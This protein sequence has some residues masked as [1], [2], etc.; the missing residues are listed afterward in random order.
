MICKRFLWIVTLLGL[1]A[2]VEVKA[3][4]F[5][6]YGGAN[7]QI[8][9][10]AEVSSG[11]TFNNY[12]T[13]QLGSFSNGFDLP[14]GW[15]Y[16]VR[17]NGNFT[18]G[19]SSIPA[20]YVSLQLG[21][22][23]GSGPGGLSSNIVSLTNTDAPL[24][25]TSQALT[26]PPAYYM[27][28]KINMIVQGGSHL[29]VQN[30]GTFSTTLTISLCNSAGVVIASK[31]NVEISFQV[32]YSN[33]C[34]G[35]ILGSQLGGGYNFDTYAKIMAGATV[36]DA[37]AMTYNPN[38][39]TCKGWSLKVRADGAFTN[40]ISTLAASYFSL[41]FNRVSNGSPS[42]AAIGLSS[43]PVQMSMADAI[44]I[45]NSG[46]SFSNYTAHQ[47]DLLIAG[48][49]HLFGATSGTYTC[50]FVFSLYNQAG[51]LLSTTDVQ[52]S[53]VISWSNTCSSV[54]LGG[55]TGTL[56][57][58]T[59]YNSLQAG[60]TATDAITLQYNTGSASCIGWSVKVKANGN[61]TNG[62]STIPSQYFSLRFNRVSAGAPT[63]AAMGVSNAEV[64]LSLTE[65]LLIN[66]SSGAFQ[67]FTAHKFD[68]VI[69]GGNHLSLGSVSG[70][71][72]CPLT[73]SL[74]NQ[75]NQLVSSTNINAQF[76]ITYNNANYTLTLSN[77]DVSFTYTSPA[78][79]AN[80]MS[81][82]KT[83]GLRIVGHNAYEVLVKTLGPNFTS[84]SNTMPV[85]VMRLENMVAG[86]LPSITSTEVALSS[87]DQRIILNP[88][89]SHLY[90]TV[91][92][93]LRY[94]IL[95]GNTV[96]SS[97]ATGSYS[98]QLIYVVLPQ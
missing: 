2:S 69:Q 80:G 11:K 79:Y 84:G 86:S 89:P 31:N 36:T 33:Y 76:K 23:S 6:S 38:G 94:F 77:P 10:E 58:F 43:T 74:Y 17:A 37:L 65:A 67:G 4:S 64:P 57:D 91:D 93:N 24:F 55:S 9:T 14:A 30:T 5:G 32:N 8:N 98:T 48:G 66:Q 49:A 96:I 47:F 27:E 81:V 88:M 97:T 52:V 22:I 90:H 34:T 71:Y 83:N 26:T 73:F 42:A 16:K 7:G 70:T 63:A 1:F 72:T 46:A 68:M 40:G 12:L 75:S 3:Q 82:T 78:D 18:N 25:S 50:K 92:Y 45:N 54:S 87:A 28:Y 39:A 62:S 59:T 56:Y 51:N 29:Y 35:V 44:L 41:R 60:G 20:Q 85:S 53:F 19:V 15:T 13:V 95:P 61:F 21:S